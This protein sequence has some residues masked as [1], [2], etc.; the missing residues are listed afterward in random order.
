VSQFLQA[1]FCTAVLQ[2]LDGPA[3]RQA[4]VDLVRRLKPGGSLLVSKPA[5]SNVDAEDEMAALV[6]DLPERDLIGYAV[7]RDETKPVLYLEIQK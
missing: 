7:W 2:G 5:D 1:S 3:A 6:R 4:L